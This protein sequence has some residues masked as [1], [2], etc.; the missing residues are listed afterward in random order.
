[1][2]RA[3]LHVGPHKTGS[4]AVQEWLYRNLAELRLE[5]FDLPT[6]QY[7]PGLFHSLKVANNLRFAGHDVNSELWRGLTAFL[8]QELLRQ[9]WHRSLEQA[10][11]KSRG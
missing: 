3:I 1:M 5:S 8:S 2:P 9:H 4:T 6:Q 7:L 10:G 11:E